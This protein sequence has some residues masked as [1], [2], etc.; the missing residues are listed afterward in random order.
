MKY[1][2]LNICQIQTPHLSSQKIIMKWTI[3]YHYLIQNMMM[4]IWVVTYRCFGS[5]WWMILT[6]NSIQ[7]Q[8]CCF[9]NTEDNILEL[10]IYCKSLYVFPHQ[11]QCEIFRWHH[12]TCPRHW[13]FLCQFP[14]CPIIYP[15]VTVYYC[16]GHLSNTISLISLKIYVDFQKLSSEPIEYYGCVD[17]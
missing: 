14:N 9:V 15:V 5:D 1:I 8:L 4:M 6:Q 3:S 13:G 7:S 17:P 2:L 12:G 16:P 10:P 11:I